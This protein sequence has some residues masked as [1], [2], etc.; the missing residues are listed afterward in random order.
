MQI[1]GPEP[2]F[3]P[4]YSFGRSTSIT[5]CTPTMTIQTIEIEIAWSHSQILCCSSQYILEYCMALRTVTAGQLH[6]WLSCPTKQDNGTAHLCSIPRPSKQRTILSNLQIQSTYTHDFIQVNKESKTLDILP[7]AHAHHRCH[8]QAA[9]K[10]P[11]FQ[12][13]SNHH[14]Q[15]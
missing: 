11:L 2:F 14:Q 3:H 4:T 6:S 7:G 13:P 10:S 9:S 12:P 1:T 5:L 8:G 15:Q